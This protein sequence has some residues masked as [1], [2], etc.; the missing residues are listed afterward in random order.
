MALPSSTITAVAGGGRS[1]RSNSTPRFRPSRRA[2]AKAAGAQ[3][4]AQL[5][6]GRAGWWGHRDL[7]ERWPFGGG[8]CEVSRAHGC[9]MQLGSQRVP[10]VVA[11]SRFRLEPQKL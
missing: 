2:S 5:Q 6:I 8:G 4:F 11:G 3:G 7:M 1:R 9:C 10:G